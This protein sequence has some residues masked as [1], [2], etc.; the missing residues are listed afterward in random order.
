MND[1]YSVA[2][3]PAPAGVVQGVDTSH[4]GCMDPGCRLHAAHT[5]PQLLPFTL[6]ASKSAWSKCVHLNGGS[7]PWPV[8]VPLGSAAA[9]AAL[10]HRVPAVTVMGYMLPVCSRQ[11][12][13]SMLYNMHVR[14]DP[15][16]LTW[17][18][19]W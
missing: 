17:T 16:L 19:C 4:Q 7:L 9:L 6:A 10:H 11:A 14:E 18:G 2:R 3:V 5:R 1:V 13:L 15:V 12:L 8:C